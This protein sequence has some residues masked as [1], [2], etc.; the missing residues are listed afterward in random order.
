M[1][2]IS[3]GASVLTFVSLALNSA[4]TIHKILSSFI[5]GNSLVEKVARDAKALQDSLERIE[6][7]DFTNSRP[8]DKAALKSKLEACQDDMVSCARKLEEL[9]LNGSESSTGRQWKKIRMVLKEKDVE[10]IGALIHRHISDLNLH[11]VVLDRSIIS[12]INTSV[13]AVQNQVSSHFNNLDSRIGAETQAIQQIHTM[14]VANQESLA[15]SVQTSF[16]KFSTEQAQTMLGIQDI[17]E[18]LQAA[19][20]AIANQD[21]T[22][23]H[24][25]QVLD[26]L[27]ISAHPTRRLDPILGEVDDDGPTAPK[28]VSPDDELT[29]IIQQTL[30]AIRGKT[31]KR[32]A[33]GIVLQ[34]TTMKRSYGLHIGTVSMISTARYFKRRRVEQFETSGAHEDQ[35]TEQGTDTRIRFSPNANSAVQ[36]SLHA[37][38][39]RSYNSQKMSISVPTLSVFNILPDSAPVFTVVQHGRLD[40]FQAMLRLGQASLR[41]Q[42]QHGRSLLFYASKEPDICRFL[43]QH[44]ADVD[45]VSPPVDFAKG[46]VTT[47][48]DQF[49][50][51]EE[52]SSPVLHKLL[53]C[54]KLLLGAGCDPLWVNGSEEVNN[55]ASYTFSS[56]AMRIMFDHSDGQIHAETK[57]YNAYGTLTTPLLAY[58][59]AGV[60]DSGF[61]VDGVSLLLSRGSNISARDDRGRTC[62]HLCLQNIRFGRERPPRCTYYMLTHLQEVKNTLAYLVQHGADV[63]AIDNWGKMASETAY[64]PYQGTVDR[65]FGP[66]QGVRGDIWDL[67]L[68]DCGF[69]IPDF[70]TEEWQWKPSFNC[71]YTKEVFK[72]LWQ[73]REHLCPYYKEAMSYDSEVD[74]HNIW[75]QDEDCEFPDSET[76]EDSEYSTDSEEGGCALDDSEVDDLVE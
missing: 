9:N 69:D 30:D 12:N 42:D 25:H 27:S 15:T 41:D 71:V 52:A 40:E 66:G 21:E 43:L 44:G 48:L 28:E 50:N 7:G 76:D 67:V 46:G 45:H 64:A 34:Q 35:E 17:K 38:V 14:I 70:R 6:N 57:I 75:E 4:K 23:R 8:G 2:A 68:A 65:R 51:V 62:L 24:L 16:A 18:T 10:G 55:S 19:M 13:S 33:P 72:A 5:D 26:S 3:V 58:C 61:S 73:G 31:G 47:A 54:R 20:A 59:G 63:H 29:T 22:T 39:R 32:K 49:P 11:L 60:G 56:N 53:E 74:E 37:V 36:K 1:E